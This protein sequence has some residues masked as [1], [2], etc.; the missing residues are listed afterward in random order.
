MSAG[1]ARGGVWGEGKLIC[2]QGLP[3]VGYGREN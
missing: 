1:F 2:L 3:G